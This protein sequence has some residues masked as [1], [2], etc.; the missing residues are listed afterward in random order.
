MPR[1]VYRVLRFSVFR[2]R[3]LVHAR[4]TRARTAPRVREYA[5]TFFNQ[6]VKPEKRIGRD[7][8]SS[9]VEIVISRNLLPF[10]LHTIYDPS[11]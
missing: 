6:A 11:R 2:D 8:S 3:F 5:S 9:D 7:I 1:H 4:D 10:Q